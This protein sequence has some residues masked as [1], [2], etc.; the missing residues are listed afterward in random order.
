MLLRQDVHSLARRAFETGSAKI[1]QIRGLQGDA[2]GRRSTRLMLRTRKDR[3]QILEKIQEQADPTASV[4]P[5]G[6]QAVD[7]GQ[8][9]GPA[10]I[11]SV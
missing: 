10:M 9:G 4:A 1:E 11:S 8:A 2:A 5:N 3:I 7:F 6:K